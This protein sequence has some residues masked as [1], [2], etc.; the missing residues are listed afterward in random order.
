MK[1]QSD[2]ALVGKYDDP[3]AAIRVPKLKKSI[4]LILIVCAPDLLL[5]LGRN[6]EAEFRQYWMKAS[7]R[8]NSQCDSIRSHC[9]KNDF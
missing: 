2:F 4:C 3:T 8:R 5:R 1:G 7:C 9:S 6:R